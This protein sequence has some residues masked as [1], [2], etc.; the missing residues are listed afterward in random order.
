MAGFCI[1]EDEQRRMRFR[2]RRL[3]Q[4][5]HHFAHVFPSPV[6]MSI[7]SRVEVA[8]VSA[9]VLAVSRSGSTLMKPA[10]PPCLSTAEGIALPLPCCFAAQE[11][12]QCVKMKLIR[13]TSFSTS[14]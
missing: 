10:A 6:R 12:R 4:P 3:A 2:G 5:A 13:T 1:A 9:S 14:E 8:G 7:R 11:S